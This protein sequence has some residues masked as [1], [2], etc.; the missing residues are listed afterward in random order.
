MAEACEL[1]HVTCIALCLLFK[2][3]ILPVYGRMIHPMLHQELDEAA[4]RLEDRQ[5]ERVK[6]YKQY[7]VSFTIIVFPL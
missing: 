1:T 7:L 2:A 3:S 6:E 4:D 5:D